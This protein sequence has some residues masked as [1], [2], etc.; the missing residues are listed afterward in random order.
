MKKLIFIFCLIGLF[1]TSTLWA[2]GLSGIIIAGGGGTVSSVPAAPTDSCASANGSISCSWSAV[3]GVTSYQCWCD[4][5]NPP[6]TSLGACTSATTCSGTN[7]TPLY[8]QNEACSSAGCSSKS[9]VATA[10]PT[11]PSLVQQG[12]YSG[13][14]TASSVGQTGVISGTD[15]IMQ[16][17]S[18]TSST[19]TEAKIENYYAQGGGGHPTTAWISFKVW[20]L[21]GQVYTLIGATPHI[22]MQTTVGL[23]TYT[24]TGITCQTGDLIGFST[25]AAGTG[26]PYG[27]IDALSGSSTWYSENGDITSGTLTQSGMTLHATYS[28]MQIQFW[29]N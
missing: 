13:I 2:S 7:G 3:S 5:S 18:L 11:A 22:S 20:R 15:V 12:G 14:L 26:T 27:S 17:Y 24:F 29:G 1:I 28:N 8:F 10:T 23:Q 6:A 21:S 16:N 19:I 4:S 9:T 25:N